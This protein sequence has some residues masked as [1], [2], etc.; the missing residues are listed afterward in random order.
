V[1][2]TGSFPQFTIWPEVMPDLTRYNAQGCPV[3]DIA[4]YVEAA[5]EPALRRT[6]RA[7]L[8][9]LDILHKVAAASATMGESAKG[10]AHDRHAAAV[11]AAQASWPAEPARHDLAGVAEAYFSYLGFVCAAFHIDFCVKGVAAALAGGLGLTGWPDGDRG[12]GEPEASGCSPG[13]PRR[14]ISPSPHGFAA[15][16]RTGQPP[17][18][19]PPAPPATGRSSQPHSSADA[20]GGWLREQRL[21][22]GWSGAEMA[23]RLRRAGQATGDAHLPATAIL[24]T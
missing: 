1:I 20:L 12:S 24:A 17:C 22:R 15:F 9:Q 6:L 14:T 3:D 21:A 11:Q 4:A 19:T 7:V 16:G 5:D 2:S 8:D 18:P 10:Q 23:R 13:L